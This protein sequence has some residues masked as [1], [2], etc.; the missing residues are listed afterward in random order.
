VKKNIIHLLQ[1]LVL[2]IIGSSSL[3]AAETASVA[4]F[5]SVAD[6][7]FDPL[8]DCRHTHGTCQI[9]TRL[10]QASYQNWD[11]IYE[12]YGKKDL[13][14]A[15][16]D[17][18]YP[19]L[20][21][22]LIAMQ[23]VAKEKNAGFV[24]IMGDFLGHDFRNEYKQYTGDRTRA[25]YEAFVKKTYQFITNEFVQTFPT[26]NIYP[27][28]GNNDSYTGDYDTVP[29]GKFLQD[30]T[31][32]WSVF[33]KDKSNQESFKRNFPKAGYY[34]VDLPSGEKQ[35]L[36]VLN[37][38]IFSTSA[39]KPTKQASLEQLDWLDQELTETTKNDQSVLLAYHIPVGVD[40]FSTFEFKFNKINE[41]WKS[42]YTSRFENILKQFKNIAALLCAHIHI[43]T[44]QAFGLRTVGHVP[45]Y[46]T[47]SISPIFGN[48]PAF[49]VFFYDVRTLRIV[50][51]DTY[52]VSIGD[53]NTHQWKKN[54]V[55][56]APNRQK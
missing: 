13:S 23:A 22:S 53:K 36:I 47:P 24:M 41:F 38:V 33:F 54:L 18:N 56:L 25:G 4:T 44:L 28:V 27:V 42:A 5:I 2:F 29:H 20:K 48:N 14:F 19:L 11:A 45:V 50:D 12:K 46:I 8:S 31:E 35:K 30:M 17:A 37:S 40:I 7:H 34:A 26:L 21:S 39:L 1:M 10:R 43:D 3:Y 52:S 49:K 16:E 9:A 15:Y 32:I 51:T 6:I 55:L